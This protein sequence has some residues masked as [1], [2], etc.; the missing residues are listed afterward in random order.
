MKKK[1]VAL[2]LAAIL[3]VVCAGCG[4]RPMI[5]TVWLF[6]E[7][8]VRMPDG[9]VVSGQVESWRD[10]EDSDMLQV[11]IDG[12]VYLTHSTNVVLWRGHETD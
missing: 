9:T 4:N 12:K 2:L 5:D 11:K 3:L 8:M 10:F 6:D 7:A 1:F